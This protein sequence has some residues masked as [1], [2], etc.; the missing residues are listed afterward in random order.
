MGTVGEDGTQQ[1]LQLR[2]LAAETAG[3]TP[4][5]YLQAVGGWKL[6][7][8]VAQLRTGLSWLAV[9]T[10]RHNGSEWAERVCQRCSSSATDDVGKTW[11]LTAR[12]WSPTGGTIRVCSFGSRGP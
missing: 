12:L 7:Q 1:Y 3:Y 9:E 6:R 11:C 2:P 10:G 8:A 4:D 5:A